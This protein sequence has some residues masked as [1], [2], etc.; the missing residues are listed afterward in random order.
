MPITT[1]AYKS[2]PS[3]TRH[4]GPMAQDFKAVFGVGNDPRSINLLDGQGVALAGVK[5]L[6]R[7]V[8]RQQSVMQRQQG[9]IAK[10]QAQ[11]AK[12]LRAHGGGG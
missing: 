6:D 2:D 5:G 12:L 3:A 10:L 9:Q 1:W 11:V 8:R 4:I 7:K